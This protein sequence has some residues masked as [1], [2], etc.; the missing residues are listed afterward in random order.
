MPAP[1]LSRQLEMGRVR[2]N[3]CNRDLVRPPKALQVVP[4]HLPR[5]GPA[6]GTAQNDHGPAW[7]RRIAAL[8]GL[9]LYL[10]NLQYPVLHG[11][12]HCLMLTLV[13][14]AFHELRSVPVT[15]EQRLQLLLADAS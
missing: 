15:D 2:G 6:F 13:F 8:P 4:V 14:T 10:A 11:S 1:P 5:S 9:I 3:V 12:S 7:S